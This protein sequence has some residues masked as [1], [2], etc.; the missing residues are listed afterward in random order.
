MR[1]TVRVAVLLASVA[2]VAAA[3]AAGV[4]AASHSP[5]LIGG[6]LTASASAVT[7]TSQATIPIHVDLT[8]DGPFVLAPEAFDVQPGETVTASVSGDPRG[9]VSALVSP[10]VPVAGGEASS[11]RLEVALPRPAGP[12]YL[13]LA[14]TAL[15]CLVGFGGLWLG[16][17]RATRRWSF[18]VERRQP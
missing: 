13:S 16:F 5:D 4:R 14:L 2:A 11:V 8:S 1:A 12:N 10:S 18:S 3:G 7:F 15:A 17:R 6:T 9:R